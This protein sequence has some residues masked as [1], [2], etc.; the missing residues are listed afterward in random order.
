MATIGL[1]NLVYADILENANGEETYGVPEKLAKAIQANISVELLEAILYADDAASEV[2]KEFKQG[3]L[4]LGIDDLG[5]YN[6]SKLLGSTVDENGVLV[7][8][9]EDS[10]SPKAIGFRCKKAN[11][12]YRYFWLYRVTFGVPSTNTQTKGESITFNTPTIEGTI[13]A[14]NR[15]DTRG[16]HPWKSE[17]TTGEGSVTLLSPVVM[18]WFASV[19]EPGAASTADTTLATLSLT[20]CSLEAFSPNVLVYRGTTTDTSGTITFSTT[21]PNATAKA[22]LNGT[23]SKESGGTIGFTAGEDTVVSIIVMN[24]SASRTYTIIVSKPATN[25]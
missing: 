7:S 2:V 10:P 9:S 17:V 19:Y 3:G 24:G 12:E 25:S 23:V 8:S 18:N 6:A 4:S 16:K 1:E 22:F 15:P 13:M 20:R 14:R 5:K 11:G 21:D